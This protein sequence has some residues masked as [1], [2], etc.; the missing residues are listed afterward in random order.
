MNTKTKA[1]FV[2]TTIGLFSCE[3][4]DV[5]FDATDIDIDSAT[6]D[7]IIKPLDACLS[8]DADALV[9]VTNGSNRAV[10]SGDAAYAYGRLCNR[11]VVD[12]KMATYSPSFELYGEQWDL[13]SS[14]GASRR[15]RSPRRSG[16][17]SRPSRYRAC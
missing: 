2:A 17:G 7:I 8:A 4:N 13:P 10:P 15:R 1:L 12:F 14:A 9:Y 3:M 16:R 11:W 5:E 6:A